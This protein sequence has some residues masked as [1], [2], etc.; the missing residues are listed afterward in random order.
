MPKKKKPTIELSNSIK[1]RLLNAFMHKAVKRKLSK[2]QYKQLTRKGVVVRVLAQN[3][4]EPMSERDLNDKVVKLTG[5]VD[6]HNVTHKMRNENLLVEAAGGLLKL[7]S[8]LLEM[9]NK[10]TSPSTSK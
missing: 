4:M 1:S 7:N 8:D 5:V 2:L 10:A 6:G 9:F 3:G